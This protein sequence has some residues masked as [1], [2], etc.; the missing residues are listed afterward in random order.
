MCLCLSG[1]D[2]VLIVCTLA[3]VLVIIV[4]IAHPCIVDNMSNVS[5]GSELKKLRD[6][7]SM[8]APELEKEKTFFFSQINGLLSWAD[9]L[10]LV[11]YARQVLYADQ[12]CCHLRDVLIPHSHH[13][14][15]FE[16]SQ[17]F[18]SSVDRKHIG[19]SH[20]SCCVKHSQE[21]LITESKHVKLKRIYMYSSAPYCVIL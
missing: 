18:P 8:G 21:N 20:I 12:I 3:S 5:I 10:K 7:V 15:H 16:Q 14:N 4:R 2:V 9:G 1:G 11:Y 13:L 17:P 6:L 19:C